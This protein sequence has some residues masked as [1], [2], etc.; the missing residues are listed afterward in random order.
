MNINRNFRIIVALFVFVVLAN[1]LSACNGISS[2]LAGS[3]DEKA[4]TMG[5]MNSPR[6]QDCMQ[7]N[8][9]NIRRQIEADIKALSVQKGKEVYNLDITTNEWLDG[10]K[11]VETCIK[12]AEPQQ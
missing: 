3:G 6:I 10:E 2:A 9:E 7:S 4:T 12:D 1:L 5:V 8:K 11:T